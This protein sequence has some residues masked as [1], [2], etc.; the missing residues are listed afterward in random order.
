MTNPKSILVEQWKRECGA[1]ADAHYDA[2]RYAERMHLFFG[3]SSA[4]LAAAVGCGIVVTLNT[5]PE[6]W[7]RS[8]A[9]VL[10]IFSVVFASVQTF[11]NYSL[12]AADHKSTA[13]RFDALRRDCEDRAATGVGPNDNLEEL[14]KQLEREN[15]AAVAVPE[16]FK[17]SILAS[18]NGG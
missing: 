11:A 13:C 17:M 9:V 3:L 15:E 6:F 4:V 8:L 1:A 12:R 7:Q 10:N 2:A 18:R 5:S 16:R 14:R